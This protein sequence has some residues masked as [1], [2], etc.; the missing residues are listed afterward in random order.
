MAAIV[1]RALAEYVLAH[2]KRQWPQPATKPRKPPP[3]PLPPVPRRPFEEQLKCFKGVV[4]RHDSR[5]V[6]ELTPEDWPPVL[7]EYRALKRAG[8]GR[9]SSYWHAMDQ[10]RA[11][12]EDGS[13]I[14]GVDN[15]ER[16]I[17]M[18]LFLFEGIRNE[19]SERTPVD[20]DK[21]PPEKLLSLQKSERKRKAESRAK[22][23]REQEA[24]R[25]KPLYVV[26]E[27]S[28]VV[29]LPSSDDEEAVDVAA[30]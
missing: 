23:H 6:E 21:L 16:A 14:A 30:E 18:A 27:E 12:L 15:A 2:A 19:W 24:A 20:R 10:H 22:K 1:H 9:V 11:A 4:V 13:P 28:G 7:A 5:P 26:D 29:T 17:L 25:T 3:A 8:R